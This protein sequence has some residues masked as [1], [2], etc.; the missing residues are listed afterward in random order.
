MALASH[1]P[2]FETFTASDLEC[3]KPIKIFSK[4]GS[5]ESKLNV[6][7][8]GFEP[9]PLRNGALSHRLRPL[10]QTVMLPLADLQYAKDVENPILLISCAVVL[11]CLLLLAALLICASLAFSP[12][13]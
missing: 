11:D 8:V 2:Q 7:A 1:E 4:P 13:G 9:M 3:H 6:T 12:S 10:G 5:S